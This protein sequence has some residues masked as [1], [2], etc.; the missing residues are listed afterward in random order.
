MGLDPE[1]QERLLS[2]QDSEGDTYFQDVP[3]QEGKDPDNRVSVTLDASVRFTGIRIDDFTSIRVSSG[4]FADAFRQAYLAADGMRALRSTEVS[5]RH[6]E[7]VSR[8]EAIRSGSFRWPET[9]RFVGPS[10]GGSGS[11]VVHQRTRP[12]RKT[13]RSSN[14][15]LSV[16][17]PG[18][19][20]G[21]MQVE[22]DEVWLHSVTGQKAELALREA[23]VDAGEWAL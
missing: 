4:T 13:G 8:V 3:P 16:E 11:P 10:S 5:G 19:R 17:L 23:I 2:L 21:S 18:G 15:Y 20:F 7:L 22:T 14:G 6:D 1:G 12:V 9:R